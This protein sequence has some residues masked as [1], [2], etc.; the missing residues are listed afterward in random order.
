MTEAKKMQ[1]LHQE[2]MQ[3]AQQAQVAKR[4]GR[5][6]EAQGLLQRAFAIEK[7]V[8]MAYVDRI[9]AEPTRAVLFRS[10][11]V[12]AKELKVP[13]EAELLIAHGLA[14]NPP[15]TIAQELR[16]IFQEIHQLKPRH[17]KVKAPATAPATSAVRQIRGVL[18]MVDGAK[19]KIRIDAETD[20][21]KLEVPANLFK[22]AKDLFENQVQATIMSKG[23]KNLLLS[24]AKA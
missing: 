1:H 20:P 9:Q 6:E 11:A 5:R 16:K 8:A 7:S 18:S 14:G 22:Q 17:K 4:E 13:R 2:A 19:H 24:I 12:L 3:L 10:A 23:K 15:E 21:Y